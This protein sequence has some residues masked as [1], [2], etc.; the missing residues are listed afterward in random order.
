MGNQVYPA[1]RDKGVH[2]PSRNGAALKLPGISV[3]KFKYPLETV[4]SSTVRNINPFFTIMEAAW[5]LAGR[6]DVKFLTFFNKRMAD[7]SDDGETFNA[8][9]GYRLRKHFGV[10]QLKEAIDILKADPDSRQAVCQIW[11]ATD[12]T[13]LTKDKACN[14]QIIFQRNMTP[15]SPLET[16]K[17]DMFVYNRSNDAI[18]GG[19]TGTNPVHFN[20]IHQYVA[21]GAGFA[22]NS[23]YMVSCNLHTYLENPKTEQLFSDPSSSYKHHSHLRTLIKYE[24]LDSDLCRFFMGFDYCLENFVKMDMSKLNLTNE[25]CIRLSHMLKAYYVYKVGKD[26]DKA[27]RILQ[28]ELPPYE[29]SEACVRWLERIKTARLNKKVS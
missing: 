27:I 10:D 25:F 3:C 9:Y 26:I 11:D 15:G 7:Y 16:K 17:L 21:D 22:T 19:V 29:W 2:T 24:K 5:M 1:L 28:E 23:M 4:C 12:L 13:S 6:R 18:W 8:A 20:A 14:T